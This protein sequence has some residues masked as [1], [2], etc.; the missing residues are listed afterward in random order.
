MK[1]DDV[2]SNPE[3]KTPQCLKFALLLPLLS[4]LIGTFTSKWL[5]GEFLILDILMTVILP[6]GTETMTN[7]C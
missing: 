2:F 1:F 7:S 3:I 6:C 4:A 5:R